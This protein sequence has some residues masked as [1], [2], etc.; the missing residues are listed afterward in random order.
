MCAALAVV[1]LRAGTASTPDPNTVDRDFVAA[2]IPHHHLGMTLLDEAAV[3][4]N[5]VRLRRLAFEM[6]S[7][8][9]DEL[10]TFEIWADRWG[11]G[12][13]T[14]FP[15]EIS[16]PELARIR[17]LHGTDHDTLWLALMI[18]HHRGA[19]TITAAESEGAIAN[20]RSMAST[21]AQVQSRQIDDMQTLLDDFCISAPS[22][23]GCP[24]TSDGESS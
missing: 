7:Y 4:S 20:A 1:A 19:L 17:S 16:E 15:G 8:H 14:S 12:A 13:A 21:I 23:P 3:N 2:M 18:R 5:D 24:G 22:A 11:V 9:A 6:G 10:A